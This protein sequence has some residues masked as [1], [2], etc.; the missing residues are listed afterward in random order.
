MSLPCSWVA[1]L[2]VL[3]GTEAAAQPRVDGRRKAE[4]VIVLRAGEALAAHVLRVAP[5]AATL[6]LFDAPVVRESVDSLSLQSFERAEVTERSLVL[7]PAEELRPGTSL[8]LTV[9]FADGK[10]PRQVEFELTSD[11]DAVDTQVEVRRG[12]K[13]EAQ[14]VA[15]LA[16]LRGRCAVTEAALAP[17]RT[18]C[19]RA[20]LAGLF[21]SGELDREW[22]VTAHRPERRA[23]A[24][25][26]RD[27]EQA[28]VF[29]TGGTVMVGMG[30]ENP[31]GQRPWAADSARL[32]RLDAEG[33]PLEE[34]RRLPVALEPE[35]VGPGESAWV[36]VQWEEPLE[37]PAAAVRLEVMDAHGR[38]LRWERLEIV[39]AVAE[40]PMAPRSRGRKVAP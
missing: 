1:V 18:R 33:R 26:V 7:R 35:R 31:L 15:A 27:A 17:L 24:Q 12:E 38:G 19:A 8:R 21:V 3:V 5:D 25:G 10:A 37:A 36:A 13:S 14:L 9:R 28:T 29:R 16:E 6:V 4:Q 34:A 32:V 30:L 23:E 22:G 2:V 40:P 20:G 11:P 39:P